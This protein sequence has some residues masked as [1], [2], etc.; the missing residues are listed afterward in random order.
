LLRDGTVLHI[1]LRPGNTTIHA[2]GG[3]AALTELCE[4]LAWLGSAFRDSPKSLGVSVCTPYIPSVGYNELVDGTHVDIVTTFGFRVTSPTL[5][6][7]QNERSSCW[8][9]MFRNPTIVE[10]FP[11]PVRGTNEHGLRI[12]FDMLYTLAE[13]QFLTS[14]ADT[15]VL[16]GFCTLLVP[17]C[18]TNHSITWHFLYNKDGRRIPYSA[19]R[20]RCENWLGT[21]KVDMQI[22]DTPNLHHYVGWSSNVTSHL[23]TSSHLLLLS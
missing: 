15:M 3:Q 12:P 22:L 21:D 9:A 4:Q 18:R 17:T 13:A 20:D 2:H 23:G 16:K 5:S 7:P 8:H 1:K 19:F 6:M 10:G 14:Y 11:I